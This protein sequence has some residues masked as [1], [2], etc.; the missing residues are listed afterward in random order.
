VSVP[1]A[2]P[3]AALSLPD[4]ALS[5]PDAALSLPAAALP[6]LPIPVP[7]L[8]QFPANTAVDLSLIS[9]AATQ[10]NYGLAV[11][12][13]LEAAY[14]FSLAPS[15]SNA[16][17]LLPPIVA[18]AVL[19]VVAGPALGQAGPSLFFGLSVSSAVSLALLLSASLRLS[20]PTPYPK[21]LAA[22]SALVAFLGLASFLQNMFA[23]E[24][25]ALP[26]L[27]PLPE[28]PSFALPELP[29]I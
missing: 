12:M 19:V 17:I 11:V 8:T 7:E 14:S 24:F 10:E 13:L 1:D 18:A 27:P 23:G 26:S 29:F 22:G 21:E 28:L 20:N 16:R 5:I 15:L 4:A 2:V 25:L 3:D 6:P 9:L